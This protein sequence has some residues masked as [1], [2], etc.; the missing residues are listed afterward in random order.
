MGLPRYDNNARIQIER[1]ELSLRIHDLSEAA[2]IYFA[3][4]QSMTSHNFHQN[5][6]L[7]TRLHATIKTRESLGLEL[8]RAS[9]YLFGFPQ[10]E[11]EECFEN[12]LRDYQAKILDEAQILHKLDSFLRANLRLASVQVTSVLELIISALSTHVYYTEDPWQEKLRLIARVFGV[13]GRRSVESTV[14]HHDMLA[15]LRQLEKFKE[16]LADL[17]IMINIIDSPT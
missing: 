9:R 2:T 6:A 14:S 3:Q 8:A 13:H 5:K 15:Q 11:D 10:L 7:Q 1:R 17:Q 4:C 12:N 16:Q